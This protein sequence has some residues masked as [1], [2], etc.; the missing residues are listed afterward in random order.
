MKRGK[1]PFQYNYMLLATIVPIIL[2]SLTS[3]MYSL[4]SPGWDPFDSLNMGEVKPKIFHSFH[5]GERMGILRSNGTG[6]N[7]LDWGFTLVFSASCLLVM[8]FKT[9]GGKLKNLFEVN[10]K[11]LKLRNIHKNEKNK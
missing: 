2:I 7:P 6:D 11:R 3:I 9:R 10:Q 1:D 4:V 8:N 5:R